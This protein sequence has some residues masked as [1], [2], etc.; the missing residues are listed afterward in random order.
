MVV[1]RNF[2]SIIFQW[3]WL[4]GTKKFGSHLVRIECLVEI[5]GAN[6][7]WN[8]NCNVRLK[9]KFGIEIE[10]AMWDWKWNYNWNWT[11]KLKLQYEIENE[12]W[13]WNCNMRLK[14]K[15]EIQI[16]IW[17]F[18]VVHVFACLFHFVLLVSLLFAN[19]IVLDFVHFPRIVH[20]FQEHVCGHCFCEN[21]HDWTFSL[22]FLSAIDAGSLLDQCL[23]L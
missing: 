22:V 10:I 15:F 12:I 17:V 14:M 9:M 18:A 13:N 19:V 23:V 21:V 5:T 4:V 6:V 1:T 8:W 3:F 20:V 7:H 2:R 16:Q 11:L